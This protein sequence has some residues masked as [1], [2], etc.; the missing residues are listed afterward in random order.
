MNCKNKIVSYDHKVNLEK[1]DHVRDAQ[2]DT[3]KII[4]MVTDYQ[5]NKAMFVIN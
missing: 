1:D 3:S 5:Y 2:I 4:W